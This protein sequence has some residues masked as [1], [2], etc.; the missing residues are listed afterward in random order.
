[1]PINFSALEAEVGGSQVQDHPGMQSETLTQNEG[2]KKHKVS[3][4]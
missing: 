1:M 2:E 4:G 3:N